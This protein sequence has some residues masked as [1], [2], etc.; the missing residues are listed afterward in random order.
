[1]DFVEILCDFFITEGCSIFLEVPSMGQSVDLVG[2]KSNFIYVVEVK[3]SDWR[4][5]IKQCKAHEI[6]ADYICVA[7]YRDKLSKNLEVEID[8]L[9]YGLVLIDKEKG[10]CFW[11]KL[12]V[13]NNKIWQ[14][15]RK[16]FEKKIFEKKLNGG[17]YAN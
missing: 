8:K 13:K 17:F 6:V 14:P 15:Q 5:A 11:R 3:I 16:Q 9:G 4:R 1:M 7:L 10:N 12:P 2:I